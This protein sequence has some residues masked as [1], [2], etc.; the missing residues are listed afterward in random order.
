MPNSHS[1]PYSDTAAG[2]KEYIDDGEAA[3]VL[4]GVIYH[5]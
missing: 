4:R 2:G 3:T 1:K 5:S